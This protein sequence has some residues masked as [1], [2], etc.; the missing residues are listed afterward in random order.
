M[1]FDLEKYGSE[2]EKKIIINKQPILE[3]IKKLLLKVFNL[4]NIPMQQI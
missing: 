3:H 1:K 4:I 2:G